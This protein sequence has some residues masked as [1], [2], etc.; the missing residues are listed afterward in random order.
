MGKAIFSITYRIVPEKREEYLEH[1]KKVKVA[2]E[3]NDG[4][5][6]TIYE[7]SSSPN[8]MSE[9]YHLNDASGVE[10]LKSGVSAFDD[11]LMTKIEEFVL[12][13]TQV[14]IRTFVE[15]I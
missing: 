15:P 10:A 1:M 7:D 4:H 14:S 13:Q 9:V 2:I 6:Y 8:L 12:D 5:A 11:A 3:K